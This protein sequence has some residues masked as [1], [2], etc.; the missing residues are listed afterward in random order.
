MIFVMLLNIKLVL[1]GKHERTVL[2]IVIHLQFA[3]AR[4]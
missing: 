3:R 4:G 2:I 1:V